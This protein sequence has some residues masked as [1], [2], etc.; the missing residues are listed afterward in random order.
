MKKLFTIFASMAI[1]SIA[2]CTDVSGTISTNTTW[3]LAGSPYIVTGDITVDNGVT[4]TVDPNVEVK[5]NSGRRMTVLG[6][7]NAN[8]VTFTSNQGSPAPGDWLYIRIGNGSFAG[9]ATLTSCFVRYSQYFYIYSGTATLTS[10]NIEYSLYYG[11]SNSGTLNMTGGVV[12]LT[13]YTSYGYGLD[14]N[15]G[16]VSNLNS[17]TIIHSHYGISLPAGATVGLNNCILTL[18]DWPIYYAGAGITNYC[19]NL[20]FYR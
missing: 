8:T 20:R 14:A 11:I 5:F 7:L 17:T 3:N 12:D 6:T 19:R 15:S 4:L 16:S 2:L 1:Y 9:S 10:T 18:N 13:G